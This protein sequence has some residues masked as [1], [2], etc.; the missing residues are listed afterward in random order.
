L[1]KLDNDFSNTASAEGYRGALKEHSSSA[2]RIYREGHFPFV[3]IGALEKD[4]T[5]PSRWSPISG[6]VAKSG[7][8]GYTY[9]IASADA[10]ETDP[11]KSSYLRIWKRQAGGSWKLVLEITNPIPD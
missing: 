8:I 4:F 2:V 6:E 9:G 3:G 10:G 5:G 1:S 11:G 7:D